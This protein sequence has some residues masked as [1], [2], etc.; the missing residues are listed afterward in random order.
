MSTEAAYSQYLFDG[1]SYT[2]AKRIGRMG[3]PS[4]EKRYSC[5]ACHLDFSKRDVLFYSG[6]PYGIP[7]GCARDVNQ[8]K[9]KR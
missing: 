4:F 5:F 8:L 3:P 7:C 9:E 1:V 2:V 6:R